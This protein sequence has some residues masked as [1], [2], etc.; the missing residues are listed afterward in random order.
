[1]GSKEQS[2]DAAAV[3]AG[4]VGEPVDA[5]RPLDQKREDY[6]AGDAGPKTQKNIE[7]A[8][9]SRR[10]A[11]AAPKKSVWMLVGLVALGALAGAVWV[12]L[13]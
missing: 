7:L 3:L 9:L 11:R 1:M 12:W 6:W 2:K 8:G 4:L 13:W 5:G 10:R